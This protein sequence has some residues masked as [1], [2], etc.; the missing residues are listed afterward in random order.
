M[1]RIWVNGGKGEGGRDTIF[2]HMKLLKLG[3]NKKRMMFT[4]YI[5]SP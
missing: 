1:D 4:V 5:H 2:S 3:Y